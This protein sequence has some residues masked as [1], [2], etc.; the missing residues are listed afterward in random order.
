MY[1]RNVP[2]NVP[3]WLLTQQMYQKYINSGDSYLQT[4]SRN[5]YEDIWENLS[6]DT[7][8]GILEPELYWH[9]RHLWY[10]TEWWPHDVNGELLTERVD[11]TDCGAPWQ[12]TPALPQVIFNPFLNADFPALAFFKSSEFIR[13]F[14]GQRL[15]LSRSTDSASEVIVLSLPN[16]VVDID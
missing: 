3:P 15:N 16:Y 4:R 6:V 2:E 8:S 10:L 11:P 1:P 9:E 13:Y 12:H 5:I 7:F 14:G